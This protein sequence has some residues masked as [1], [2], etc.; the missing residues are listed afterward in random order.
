MMIPTIILKPASQHYVE[1]DSDPA[2]GK[3][4]S[5]EQSSVYK[6]LGAEEHAFRIQDHE[7]AVRLIDSM[8]CRLF[9]SVLEYLKLERIMDI[10]RDEKT[11]E[12]TV[13]EMCDQ[14]FR[15]TLNRKELEALAHEILIFAWTS[16]P[17]SPTAEASDLKSVEC[18][19]ESSRGE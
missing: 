16:S 15:V 18:S 8:D 14:A 3:W 9:S 17:R 11:R 13:E 19:F 10:Y 6:V 1:V 7:G 4:Y 2:A 5:H 12:I